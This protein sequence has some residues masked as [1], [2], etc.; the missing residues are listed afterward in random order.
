MQGTDAFVAIV[1]V[2]GSMSLPVLIVYFALQYAQAKRELLSK[3]R[4]AA[5]EKGL[6]VPL[7]DMPKAEGRTSPLGMAFILIAAGVG[8][9][10]ALGVMMGFRGPVLFPAVAACV[11]VAMVVHWFAGGREYWERERQLD[12]DLRR[13][14]IDRLRSGGTNAKPEA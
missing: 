5:I 8:A 2:A 9:S 6:D 4:L 13:A 1:S 10:L 11:G 12:E 14:Y 3:E 7:L